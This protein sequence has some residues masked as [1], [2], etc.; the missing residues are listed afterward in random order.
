MLP[1]SPS[2]LRYP[3]AP[4]NHPSTF[5]YKKNYI[6]TWLHQ[7][8]VT[9]WEIFTLH[10]GI[11]DLQL[12]HVGSSSQTMDR[13]QAPCL[14]SLESYLLDHQGNPPPLTL[15]R[16]FICCMALRV[17]SSSVYLEGICVYTYVYLSSDLRSSLKAGSLFNL[18]I[19]FPKVP[20]YSKCGLLTSSVNHTWELLQ[21]PG[22]Q[23]SSQI[24]WAQFWRAPSP[25]PWLQ[26]T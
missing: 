23:S 12:Q 2:L 17:G 20:C 14:G 25:D 19:W 21:N 4:E 13:T 5:L 26:H 16:T 6:F 9:A 1:C 24:Q 11:Q 22:S 3:T 7:I 8:L 15:N 18:I 10:C